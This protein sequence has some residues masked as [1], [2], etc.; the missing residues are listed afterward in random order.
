M[1][2]SERAETKQIISVFAWARYLPPRL[3][4]LTSQL[5]SEGS[6]F[7]GLIWEAGCEAQGET[8]GF[9]YGAPKKM[10]Q[11]QQAAGGRLR[12][13]R[14]DLPTACAT[15]PAALLSPP[16]LPPWAWFP[17]P[18]WRSSRLF[19]DTY[20]AVHLHMYTYVVLRCDVRDTSNGGFLFEWL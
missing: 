1:P 17:T 7:G 5:W 20:G 11:Q 15:R 8:G 6:K 16:S 12:A 9:P 10:A 3:V 2:A 14:A 18:P 13:Y 19:A 4:H